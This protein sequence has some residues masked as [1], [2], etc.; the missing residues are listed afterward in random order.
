MHSF[1]I[2]CMWLDV[3]GIVALLLLF[4][5]PPVR[6]RCM[7]WWR[8]YEDVAWIDRF[9][10]DHSQGFI[11]GEFLNRRGVDVKLCV[12]MQRA[13]ATSCHLRGNPTNPIFRLCM[14]TRSTP[15]RRSPLN[16][17]FGLDHHITALRPGER[18]LDQSCS[19]AGDWSVGP[20]R[21]S[22]V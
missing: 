20:D 2:D 11:G 12:R 5:N 15:C 14:A 3:L 10:G 1:Y 9:Y 18:L 7:R 6:R 22:R 17:S 13:C 16:R 4:L 21:A 8:G 19:F